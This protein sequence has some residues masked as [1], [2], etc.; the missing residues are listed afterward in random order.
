[1]TLWMKGGIE[2][3][4]MDKVIQLETLIKEHRKRGEESEKK[5]LMIDDDEDW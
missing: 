2:P 4:K 3:F 1:M 5:N